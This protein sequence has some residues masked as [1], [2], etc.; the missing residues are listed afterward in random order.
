MSSQ[1]FAKFASVSLNR[2]LKSLIILMAAVNICCAQSGPD[3]KI[4]G[5]FAVHPSN[6]ARFNSPLT[7]FN[8]NIY[9]AFI[10]PEMKTI[11]AQKKNNAWSTAIISNITQENP[12]HNAPSLGVDELGFVHVLY[13]MH[14]TPWQ[15]KMSTQSD[16]I[17]H[18]Q[19]RGQYAGENPGFST[20]KDSR[21]EGDCFDNWLG[22]GIAD[23]PGNQIGYMFLANDRNGR[24]YAAF[25][26]CNFCGN[27]YHQRQRSGGIAVYDAGRRKWQRIGGARPWATDSVYSTQG[28]H[29]YFDRSNRMHVSWV[30]GKH[31]TPEQSSDAFWFNPNF[32][33]Y[34]YSD[35]GGESFFNADGKALSLPIDFAE[36]SPVIHPDWIRNPQENGYFWGYTEITAAPDGKP[37]V[38]V[39][40]RTE[41]KPTVRKSF[42]WWSG[43]WSAPTA[44]PWGGE[45]MV[46]DSHGTITVISSGIRMH[47]SRDNGKTWENYEIDLSGPFNIVIDYNFIMHSDAIRFMGMQKN[48]ENSK[49]RIYTV[50]FPTGDQDR[51]PPQP[52]TNIKAIEK[53]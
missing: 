8:D 39:F 26:E 37:F 21:C 40:P 50:R 1:S 6:I 11:V 52:P 19:F 25:R 17:S 35:D 43:G 33:C 14:A 4:E 5:E 44:L 49:I 18:W 46:I 27:S 41:S 13:N 45:D 53:K 34:V 15:Y 29:F 48:G 38:L 36:S 23:I 12:Y 20:A 7:S 9:V 24:L 10:S 2:L 42:L 51:T 22:Q 47:R 32:P 30:W 31:Y 28:L 16:D 3:I